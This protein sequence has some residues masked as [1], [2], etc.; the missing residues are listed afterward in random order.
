MWNSKPSLK[1]VEVVKTSHES[2]VRLGSL[3]YLIGYNATFPCNSVD[4]L[5]IVVRSGKKGKDTIVPVSVEIPLINFEDHFKDKALELLTLDEVARVEGF[6]GGYRRIGATIVEVKFAPIEDRNLLNWSTWQFIG[7]LVAQSCKLQLRADMT[8]PY[9]IAYSA[10]TLNKRAMRRV[11]RIL[12]P[13]IMLQ[14]SP[15]GVGAFILRQLTYDKVAKDEQFK[16]LIIETLSSPDM[17]ITVLTNMAKA[18]A[19]CS[20]HIRKIENDRLYSVHD[21]LLLRAKDVV[22]HY[23]EFPA[24]LEK[25]KRGEPAQSYY[26]RMVNR[27]IKK[28]KSSWK[29]PPISLRKMLTSTEETYRVEPLP[30]MGQD[31][32]P[33]L[34]NVDLAEMEKKIVVNFNEENNELELDVPDN[35]SPKQLNEFVKQIKKELKIKSPIVFEKA[36]PA[37]AD[38]EF[39][40]EMVA[41]WDNL[42]DFDKFN[43]PER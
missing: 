42:D 39:V 36:K 24:E 38:N 31:E 27:D 22:A 25:L 29:T 13:R 7:F 14:Q 23:T 3:A 5:L 1:F 10:K 17:R 18:Y 43:E 16:S 26:N 28:S 6:A 32:G 8:T 30:P 41:D 37:A 9:S 19:M 12:D 2:R 35:V 15:E 11:E 20:K 40:K 21:D 34:I 4:S 33:R